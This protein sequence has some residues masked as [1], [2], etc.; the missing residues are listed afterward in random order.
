MIEALEH[1]SSGQVIA[2]CILVGVVAWGLAHIHAGTKLAALVAKAKTEAAGV[3]KRAEDYTD[4]EIAKLM[5]AFVAR[6][7]DTSEQLQAK[8]EADATIAR[9][10]ALVTRVQ[11]VAAAA[12]VKTA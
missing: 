3:E 5:G 2:L 9:K 10:A 7:A 6:L 11:A 1:L 8:A 4:A 12:V